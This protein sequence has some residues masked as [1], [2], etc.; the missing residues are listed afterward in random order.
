MQYIARLLAAALFF[1][2]VATAD[3]QVQLSGRVIDDVSGQ[4]IVE[5]AVELQDARGR[6]LAQHTTDDTGFFRFV[7]KAAGPVRLQADRIGYRRVTTPTIHFDGYTMYGVEIRLAVDA[8]LLAPLEVVAR[9]RTPVSPTLAGFELRRAT[10]HGWFVSR[11]EIER[12][13]PS[14]VTDLLANA[15]GVQVQ[16]RIVYMAR[17]QNCPAQIYID[18][19]HINREIRPVAGRRGGRTST[20]LFPIDDMVSPNAV[21]GI[22][23][24]QGLS[25]V[26]A[27]FLTPESSCGVVAIWTRRGG[28]GA[29]TPQ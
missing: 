2:G 10:G 24:Y 9:S 4:P 16:R 11:G 19:F 20:E 7:I 22:E 17:A 6:R 29:S 8:V 18:G 25:R 21:E 26:P 23:V 15:P 14:R 3:A 28:A 1:A 27:E 12:R 13:N 5:A